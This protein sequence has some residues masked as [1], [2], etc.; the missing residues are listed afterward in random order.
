MPDYKKMYLTMV[1]A[2]EKAM[3]VMFE[4]VQKSKDI[5]ASAGG[6]LLIGLSKE[7]GTE[8]T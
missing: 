5:Y 4:A 8:K 7:T 3:T 1:D 6:P 2:V